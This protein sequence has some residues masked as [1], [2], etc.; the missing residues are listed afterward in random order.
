MTHSLTRTI[1]NAVLVLAC[2]ILPA[3]LFAHHS[4]AIFD[5]QTQIPFEG[6][7]ETLKFRNPHIEM[8][9]KT[10]DEQGNEKIVHFIEGAPANMLARQGL[11]PDM[12][13]KGTKVTGIGSPLIEDDSKFFLRSIILEDGREFRN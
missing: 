6:T 3:S 2:A 13:K 7:V 11:K 8:T 9:L 10:V 12:L 1:R 4:F 5:F